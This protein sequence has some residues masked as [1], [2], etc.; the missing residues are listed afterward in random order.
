MKVPVCYLRTLVVNQPV[1]HEFPHRTYVTEDGETRTHTLESWT[2]Q[3]HRRGP[4]QVGANYFIQCADGL[5]EFDEATLLA[6]QQS[7]WDLV[8]GDELNA[9]R[10]AA[11][12]EGE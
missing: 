12:P 10:E 11:Q 6:L 2:W 8:T 4:F 9:A 1:P 7:N 5:Q 3:H